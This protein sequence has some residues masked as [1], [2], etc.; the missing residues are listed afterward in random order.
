M[1]KAVFAFFL[2]CALSVFAYAWLTPLDTNAKISTGE[3][4]RIV[5][6]CNTDFD[7]T[8]GELCNGGICQ[9][10][11][12]CDPIVD[13]EWTN[14]V[15]ITAGGEF[16][17]VENEDYLDVVAL[18]GGGF[19][20]RVY[21]EGDVHRAERNV[22][23]DFPRPT[24]A[25]GGKAEVNFSNIVEFHPNILAFIGAYSDDTMNR[26]FAV[27]ASRM[28]GSDLRKLLSFNVYNYSNLGNHF[29]SEV[30]LAGEPTEWPDRFVPVEW[31]I[32]PQY[33]GFA[34]VDNQEWVEI[35]TQEM[36]HLAH[37]TKLRLGWVSSYNGG[38]VDIKSFQLFDDSCLYFP[39]PDE[40]AD[41]R[42]DLVHA[43]E[44][45]LLHN[46]YKISYQYENLGPD[47]SHNVLFTNQYDSD[48]FVIRSVDSPGC[49]LENS[50]FFYCN[51][52]D[53]IPR[54]SIDF[55]LEPVDVGPVNTRAV[56]ASSTYD[57]D[58][59]NNGDVA[60]K[61][62]F[63]NAD[64]ELEMEPNKY[65]Y[66][67]GDDV[68][69]F[70]DYRN[71]GPQ[72]SGWTEL[73]IEYSNDRLEINDI[74]SNIME[75][76]LSG[77][78][79]IYCEIESLPPYIERRQIINLSGETI[80][81]GDLEIS[82]EINARYL[83]DEDLSNNTVQHVIPVEEGTAYPRCVI[84]D[85]CNP[86]EMCH[87]GECV[88]IFSCEPFLDATWTDPDDFTAGGEFDEVEH[89][90]HL[91]LVPAGDAYALRAYGELNEHTYERDVVKRFH[92][93]RR[94][95]G[96]KA[97]VNLH[98]VADGIIGPPFLAFIG[99]YSD[100]TLKRNFGFF[101]GSESYL[102]GNTKTLH[103]F[104]YNYSNMGSTYGSKHYLQGEPDE[105]P[106]R[107]VPIEWYITPQMRGFVRI[108]N[109]EWVEIPT[110][111]MVRPDL[112]TSFRAGWVSSY[113]GGSVDFK[114][115][116][117]Y[118]DRCFPEPF[119]GKDIALKL[120]VNELPDSM[121]VGETYTVDLSLSNSS[122]HPGQM[123]TSYIALDEAIFNIQPYA[124]SGCL[125]DYNS[126]YCGY[127]E[128]NDV[129]Q[130][131]LFDITPIAPART[132]TNIRVSSAM[133]EKNLRDNM[134]SIPLYIANTTDLAIFADGVQDVYQVGELSTININ[135]ENNGP[136]DATY[137]EIN[138]QFLEEVV[139]I[140][141]LPTSDDY[142]CYLNDN[143]LYFTCEVQYFPYD[144]DCS[145]DECT[146]TIPV[147]I[148]TVITG[149]TDL[150]IELNASFLDDRD[151]S[152]NYRVYPITVSEPT[153]SICTV[154]AKPRTVYSNE[155]TVITLDM[156]YTMHESAYYTYIDFGDGKEERI[157]GRN[158][159]HE[160]EDDGAYDIKVIFERIDDGQRT[161]GC[162]TEVEVL[163]KPKRTFN[164]KENKSVNRI[165]IQ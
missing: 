150:S 87:G 24:R 71:N 79:M 84:D 20:L 156:P 123:V 89:P 30:L 61:T 16:D 134:V 98:N 77:P 66:D 101:S 159:S 14:P 80:S 59:A 41:I 83:Y 42:I 100:D 147:D 122:L 46:A 109:Q 131:I 94:S 144:P 82:A 110:N 116:Q 137:L 50:Q 51:L 155:E 17:W 25:F 97:Y 78:G 135:Y 40:S 53:D 153:N 143:L 1:K 107:F 27:Y 7:C 126:L 108:D 151:P 75:C 33:R 141:S 115:I 74:Q 65:R 8:S 132:E 133:D 91:E 117:L 76:E 103:P 92:P 138:V 23:V 99:G 34:R 55:T 39:N 162:G 111:K 93:P 29:D 164:V 19:A 102:Q 85:E 96:G 142:W 145:G 118:D 136:F 3:A 105:W 57:Y 70:L 130:N 148:R 149:Q 163:E 165:T 140:D 161:F 128:V 4:V 48:E 28:R 15:D 62:V 10:I 154:S 90:E 124:P 11:F 12:S 56:V 88:S 73:D 37:F 58:L 129:P 64:L 21:G 125:I 104:L 114:S 120:E 60:N 152:N 43:P 5:D 35:P 9:S 38:S 106:D 54:G 22:G 67:V 69:I 26:N 45:Y 32:T 146:H 63:V 95:W 68:E 52:S 113:N 18:D 31:Y 13:A 112:F 160:Y 2:V 119:P 139:T 47:T 49:V 127:D 6:T 81:E 121:E 86:G 44:M 157:S 36:S 72:D 158:I